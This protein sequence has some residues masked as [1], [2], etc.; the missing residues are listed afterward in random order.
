LWW[1]QQALRLFQ[2][3][4]TRSKWESFC[5]CLILQ[6]QAEA[7]QRRDALARANEN[8]KR[9]RDVEDKSSEVQMLSLIMTLNA[10]LED[11][12][13]ILVPQDISKE[14]TIQEAKA[15]MHGRLAK[16]HMSSRDYELAKKELLGETAIWEELGCREGFAAALNELA[17][18]YLLEGDGQLCAN[19][20]KQASF[21]AREA[22][23]KDHLAT[24]LSLLSAVESMHGNVDRSIDLC[25]EALETLEDTSHWTTQLNCYNQL[26][27]LYMAQTR[28][29]DALWAARQALALGESLG[30]SLLHIRL[31]ITVAKTQALLTTELDDSEDELFEE[32][33]WG[34]M[35][36]ARKALELARRADENFW[37]SLSLF[38]LGEISLVDGD[39]EEAL[40]LATEA[41]TVS[42]NCGD[43]TQ[44]AHAI[45][46]CAHAHYKIG[47]LQK[48]SEMARK[49]LA[50][51][52]EVQDVEGESAVRAILEEIEQVHQRDDSGSTRFVPKAIVEIADSSVPAP[53]VQG[54]EISK[55]R[56]FLT[57]T[58]LAVARD[59]VGDDGDIDLDSPLMEAG[60]DS[61]S[62]VSFRNNLLTELDGVDLPATVVFEYPTLHSLVSY[63]ME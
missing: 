41:A 5:I 49:G 2:K 34:A 1:A 63:L 51:S 38:T 12:N 36:S 33:L 35:T 17:R 14:R 56:D 16:K 30:D 40:A 20:A 37:I 48:A 53:V 19:T 44:E 8:L 59:A 10:D 3:L 46:L 43:P 47:N 11:S 50:M 57:K 26:N 27:A 25:F 22:A 7:G 39:Y 15:R 52:Q 61:L 55:D 60:M 54:K 4:E 23:N 58:V 42:I 18:V 29:D 6:C 62:M 9:F 31:L 28:H 24:S 32:N 45:G 21:V 13:E